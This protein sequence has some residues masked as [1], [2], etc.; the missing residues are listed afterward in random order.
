M[1][2]NK[3]NKTKFIVI[4]SIITSIFAIIGMFMF[5]KLV[6]N[7]KDKFNIKKDIK[8]AKKAQLNTSNQSLQIKVVGN[9]KKENELK[10]FADKYKEDYITNKNSVN[11][12]PESS[13]ENG[14]FYI[15]NAG[16]LYTQNITTLDD[17][18]RIENRLKEAANDMK[19]VYYE[20]ISFNNDT[21]K[22]EEYLSKGDNKS[23][24]SYLYGISD[25]NTLK[26]FICKLTF[27]KDSKVDCGVLSNIKKVDDNNIT[28]QFQIKTKEGTSQNFNISIN[29]ADERAIL[30]IKI[31]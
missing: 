6:Y 20:T 29:F 23:R 26:L 14:E 11:S 19:N 7:N 31:S 10:K 21:D 3:N 27:L 1:R 4:V 25:E 12:T 9:E 15:D 8:T 28:F 22:L 18:F 30:N 17:R 5:F 24:F 16:E 2:F 13:A